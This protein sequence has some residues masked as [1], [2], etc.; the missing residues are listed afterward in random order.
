[1]SDDDSTRIPLTPRNFAKVLDLNGHLMALHPALTIH[2]P[3]VEQL[4]IRFLQNEL[5]RAGFSRAVVGLSGGIDST[6][7]TCLAARALGPEQVLAVT[8]PYKTSSAATRDDAREVIERLGVATVDVP[9]TEQ[10]YKD[11]LPGSIFFV[12]QEECLLRSFVITF[13]KNSECVVAD[14]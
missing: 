1:M 11:H 9:I 7:V 4:L 3:L 10:I 6:V 13:D 5:Q 8:M 12:N 14:K 2:C